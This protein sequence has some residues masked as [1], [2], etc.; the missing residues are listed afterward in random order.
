MDTHSFRIHKDLWSLVVVYRQCTW[1]KTLLQCKILRSHSFYKNRD[2]QNYVCLYCTEKTI[3]LPEKAKTKIIWNL[4]SK[5]NIYK[6]AKNIG[7][8]KC[9][10]LYSTWEDMGFVVKPD[11]Q[12]R[13]KH[14][15]KHTLSVSHNHRF[16]SCLSIINILLVSLIKSYHNLI[17]VCERRLEL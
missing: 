15:N 11:T 3:S 6:A 9:F 17:T 2:E 8:A 16:T 13:L 5:R 12:Y 14:Q 4:C 7:T 1:K 10:V